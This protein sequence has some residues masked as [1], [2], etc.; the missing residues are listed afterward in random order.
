MPK[1]KPEDKKGKDEYIY[2]DFADTIDEE[3]K[4]GEETGF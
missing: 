2:E 3:L 4:K 1:K